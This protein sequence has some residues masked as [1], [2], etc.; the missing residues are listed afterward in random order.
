MARRP[1]YQNRL[2]DEPGLY[3]TELGK[4]IAADLKDCPRCQCTSH[5]DLLVR[6]RGEIVGCQACLPSAEA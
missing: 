2:D 1:A 3:L 6:C 4:R 5:V